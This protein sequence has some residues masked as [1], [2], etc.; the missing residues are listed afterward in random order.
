MIKNI[1][2]FTMII[3]LW[4]VHAHSNQQL[5]LDISKTYKNLLKVQNLEDRIL[6]VGQLVQRY[7]NVRQQLF[8]KDERSD[9]DVITIFQITTLREFYDELREQTHSKRC[10]Q[11][12][13]RI[14]Y[15][16]YSDRNQQELP[17]FE[18]SV[19]NLY[20]RMCSL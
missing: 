4:A 2:I 17:S 13:G 8:T 5:E 12:L 16:L 3:G 18:R 6:L 10:I 19:Y 9:N 7:S 1:F 15:R 14:A 20:S 11:H